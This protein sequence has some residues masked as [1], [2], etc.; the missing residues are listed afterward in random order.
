MPTCWQILRICLSVTAT[1][2]N[3]SLFESSRMTDFDA[4][5]KL[6]PLFW[7]ATTR[8]RIQLSRRVTSWSS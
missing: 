6:T 5:V 1:A 2:P 8:S 4:D 3:S 7:S